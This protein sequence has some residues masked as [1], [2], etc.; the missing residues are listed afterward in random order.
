MVMKFVVVCS[1][2]SFFLLDIIKGVG[3]PVR[4][5]SVSFEKNEAVVWYFDWNEETL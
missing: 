4:L 2:E 3:L 1:W 5:L